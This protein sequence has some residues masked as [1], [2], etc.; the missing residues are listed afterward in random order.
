[1]RLCRLANAGTV[2]RIDFRINRSGQPHVLDN[3]TM[4]G[5]ETGNSYALAAMNAGCG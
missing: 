3:N 2:A 4:P 5:F 1:M